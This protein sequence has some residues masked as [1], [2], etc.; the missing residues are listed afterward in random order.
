MM[1]FIA[2]N[3]AP[4]M[5]VSLVVFLLLGRGHYT[6][7]VIIAYFITTRLWYSSSIYTLNKEYTIEGW[8]W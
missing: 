7:D 1:A 4:I 3:L 6:V 8:T 5:F 2:E